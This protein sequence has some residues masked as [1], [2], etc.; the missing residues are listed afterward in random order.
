MRVGAVLP[1][2]IGATR[3]ESPV[4]RCRALLSSD[5][6]GVETPLQKILRLTP[7]KGYSRVEQGRP[8][9]VRPYVNS[10]TKNAQT[11]PHFVHGTWG[12]L[13]VGDLIS[14]SNREYKVVRVNVPPL[15]PLTSGS[16]GAGVNTTGGAS[17]GSQGTGVNTGGPAST[18]SQGAGVNTTGGATTTG[19]SLAQAVMGG[20]S[21]PYGAKTITD[22]IQDAITGTQYYVYLPPTANILVWAA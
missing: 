15:P 7:V 18:G 3:G 8:Q 22:V 20:K 1:E 12:A 17:S 6:P 2:W 10:K 13:K 11:G 16:Q 19:S 9:Q 14:I 21:V 5:F 4:L